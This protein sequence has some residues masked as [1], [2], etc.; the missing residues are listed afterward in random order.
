MIT[1]LILVELK[2]ISK[3]FIMKKK[4][5]ITLLL[6]ST[7]L[8]FACERDE[9]PMP[10][11]INIE[12]V[13][14]ESDHQL[15]SLVS[16]FYN[17]LEPKN[18]MKIF[19]DINW[20]NVV[21]MSETQTKTYSFARKR[22]SNKLDYLENIIVQE[23]NGQKS[24]YILKFYSEDKDWLL[25][26]DPS[27]GLSDFTGKVTYHRGD[28]R[29][30]G[31]SEYIKGESVR[32]SLLS[33]KSSTE[34][35]TFVPVYGED[36]Q[37]IDKDGYPGVISSFHWEY[38]P[39]PQDDPELDEQEDN[40]TTLEGPLGGGGSGYPINPNN[41]D[42]ND[43]DEEI[44][45]P[46]M[47]GDPILDNPA[48]QQAMQELWR[49]SNTSEYI[50][51]R[52]ETAGWVV[53]N[54]DGSLYFQRVEDDWISDQCGINPPSTGYTIPRNAIAFIHTHPYWE[55]ENVHIACGEGFSD[56][57]VS[58]FSSHDLSAITS[59]GQL[60]GLPTFQGY[61]IDGNNITRT[62][63]LGQG[64]TGQFPRCGY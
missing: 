55:G 13:S 34:C 16:H 37:F 12:S 15:R 62:D 5:L 33:V 54:P 53:Q 8:L 48:V 32:P 43:P 49:D 64:P 22:T 58:G 40:N 52:Y 42:N 57:Y 59:W 63:I 4:N 60:L 19:R 20:M 30:I 3:Q 10:T 61:V 11:S 31:R 17:E 50:L 1:S 28:D 24:I 18:F 56:S 23:H 14:I 41:D 44:E 39:C 7:A 21:K 6:V 36:E 45:D 46:C 25:S 27:I 38:R 47:T 2:D 26:Y 51:Y 29:L 9:I 35:N